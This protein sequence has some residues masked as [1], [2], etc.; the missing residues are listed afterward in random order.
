[1]ANCSKYLLKKNPKTVIKI[2]QRIEWERI[3]PIILR[4][5]HY[6]NTGISKNILEKE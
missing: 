5:L 4:I 3:L 1:M 6:F 2:F